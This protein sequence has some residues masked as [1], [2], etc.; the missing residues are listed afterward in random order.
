MERAPRPGERERAGGPAS[1][2][3]RSGARH[4]LSFGTGEIEGARAPAA[5]GQVSAGAAVRGGADVGLSFRTGETVD[6]RASGGVLVHARG[7]EC[8]SFGLRPVRPATRDC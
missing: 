5:A 4:R 8:R 7:R 1:R 3:G 6:A 2:V